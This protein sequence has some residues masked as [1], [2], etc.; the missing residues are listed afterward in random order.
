[1]FY[2]SSL[3]RTGIASGNS[4]DIFIEILSVNLRDFWYNLLA[5]EELQV[6]CLLPQLRTSDRL[7]IF[8]ALIKILLRSNLPECFRQHA[9]SSLEVSNC[10]QCYWA[11]HLYSV[12]C[13]HCEFF[14]KWVWPYL[15]SLHQS[16]E[17]LTRGRSGGTLIQLWHCNSA[18]ISRL[19]TQFHQILSEQH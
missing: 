6:M 8:R 13:I 3:Q 10:C 19:N 15:V 11:Q 4:Q 9:V 5:P 1:M 16:T 17:S 12:C 14:N 18:D 2:I 7:V